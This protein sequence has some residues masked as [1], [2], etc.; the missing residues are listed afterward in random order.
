MHPIRER[1]GY[2][3]LR[4]VAVQCSTDGD[5]RVGLLSAL[6]EVPF[7]LAIQAFVQQAIMKVARKLKVIF[8]RHQSVLTTLSRAFLLL[9]RFPGCTAQPFLWRG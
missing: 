8:F 1:C 5:L 3:R 7:L 9:I 2:K 4:A 6:P